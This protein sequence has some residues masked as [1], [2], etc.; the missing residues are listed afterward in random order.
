MNNCN[1]ISNLKEVFNF[2]ILFAIIYL[3]YVTYIEPFSTLGLLNNTMHHQD[4]I[5][6]TFETKAQIIFKCNIS[7]FSLK[8][9]DK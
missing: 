2:R 8:L 4:N 6:K 1:I 9:L 3:P 5:N 7:K